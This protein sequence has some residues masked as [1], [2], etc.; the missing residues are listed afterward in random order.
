MDV[1]QFPEKIKDN[2]QLAARYI[3]DNLK[4]Y[5]V[6]IVEC[7]SDFVASLCNVDKEKMLS[8]CLDVDVSHARWLFFYA[9]RYMTGDTYK[10]IGKM[11][12]KISGKRFSSVG[13]AKC[14]SCM[15]QLMQRD[16][17]WEAKWRVIQSGIKGIND[18]ECASYTIT[19]NIPQ[20]LINKVKIKTK[21]TQ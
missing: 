18:E 5:D 16:S 4:K 20:Q 2:N 6:N 1:K 12:E 19:V 13:V 9:Y 11:T 15:Q 3:C 7:L 17:V 14:V 10:K 8:G 21:I